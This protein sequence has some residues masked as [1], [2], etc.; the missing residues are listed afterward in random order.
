MQPIRHLERLLADLATPERY[1][2]SA[3]DLQTACPR[4]AN[5]AVLLSR[6]AKSGILQRVCRG[7]YLYPR[8]DFPRGRILFHAAALLRANAFNYVSLETALSDAG[9]ISQIPI[10]RVTLMSSGRTH[11][12]SCGDFGRIEFVHTD[13]RP[14]VLAGQLTYD[15]ACRLWR[16]SP[17]LA[18]RDM[19]ATRR[20]LS[21]VNPEVPRESV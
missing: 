1:L 21:L 8:V 17:A 13:R 11:V 10:D 18:L 5:L 16:A 7:I 19:R 14:D 3:A 12:V 20:D 2:F 4:S 15:A 9:L 6:A